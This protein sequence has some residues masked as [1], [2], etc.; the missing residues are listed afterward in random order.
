VERLRELQQHRAEDARAAQGSQPELRVVRGRRDVRVGVVG[1]IAMRLRRERE[2]GALLRARGPRLRAARA[3]GP[4]ERAVD[5]DDVH[6]AR[7]EAETVEA[8]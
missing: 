4:V 2:A 5:L 8:P 6:E 3:G 7:Q 1:E